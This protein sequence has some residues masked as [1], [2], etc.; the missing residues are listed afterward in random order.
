MIGAVNKE[1]GPK[2][3]QVAQVADEQLPYS[4]GVVV[5]RG[6]KLD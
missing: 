1:E 2:V 5:L 6:L 3:S 4:K